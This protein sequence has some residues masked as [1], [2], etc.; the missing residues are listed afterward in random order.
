MEKMSHE[1]NSS[2]L[3]DTLT[4]T[5]GINAWVKSG[6]SETNKNVV[7]I[8]DKMDKLLMDESS[9]V[10]L[11][12]VVFETTL[13]GFQSGTKEDEEMAK[14]VFERMVALY[15][16]G[17][18]LVQPS[19]SSCNLVLK[20]H[21]ITAKR[22]DRIKSLFDAHDMLL[23]FA[24]RYTL[25]K[26]DFLPNRFGFNTVISSWA[27]S[28]HSMAR[29][30]SQEL[31]SIMNNLSKHGVEDIKP[32]HY[33]NASILTM[34]SK[35]G[36]HDAARKAQR[37]FDNLDPDNV[38]VV[39]Y[40]CLLSAWAKS[41]EKKKVRM[42][43]QIL[44]EMVLR[45][46]V[47][48]ISYNIFLNACAFSRR[49]DDINK[50]TLALALEGYE[51][52]VASYTPNDVSFKTIIRACK[53]LSATKDECDQNLKELFEIC[54]RNGVVGEALIKGLKLHFP[55]SKCEEVLGHSL[56]GELTSEWTSKT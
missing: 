13:Q 7:E 38:D 29:N 34:L 45:K 41:K 46:K 3:P 55:G 51:E 21:C 44:G 12:T 4:Y 14:R 17:N 43:R 33:T 18:K 11:D 48:V 25:K 50:Q 23:K 9:S 31:Y 1:G 19:A 56:Q 6:S 40:N 2:A 37:F 35:S 8:F 54:C 27:S 32:D 5:S 52:L 42:A 26:T 47:D 53:T 36:R 28:G 22:S 24:H 15:Q 30:K 10:Q 49:S 39:T 20:A 16:D